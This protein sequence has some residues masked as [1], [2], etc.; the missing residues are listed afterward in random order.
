M[1]TMA[2]KFAFRDC[3]I[4]SGSMRSKIAVKPRMSENS[5]AITLFSPTS[6]LSGL[7][8]YMS[9]TSFGTYFWK[10]VRIF[11]SFFLA[12]AASRA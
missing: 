1:S 4:C 2:A 11:C 9:M 6:M 5:T 12:M 10:T 3:T 8:K 7:R